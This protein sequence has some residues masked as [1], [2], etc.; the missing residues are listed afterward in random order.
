MKAV[1]FLDEDAFDD[2]YGPREK[3]EIQ[4]RLEIEE[5]LITRESYATTD[6]VWYGV[7][8][9]L[10]GWGMVAMDKVFLRRFPD[11]ELILYGAGTVQALVTPE[12]WDRNIRITSAYGANAVPVAEFTLS[13]IL[14]SLKHGWRHVRDIRLQKRLTKGHRPPGGYGSTVGLISLGMVGQLVAQKLQSFDLNVIAYDPFL[15][16]D[17]AAKWNVTLCSLEEIFARADVVSC[18]SPWTKQTE[19]M[20]RGRHFAMMKPH[21]TFINTARGAVIAENEMIEML[22]ERPDLFALLDVTHPEPPAEG[23]PLYTLE[24]VVLTPHLAGSLGREC[25]RMGSYMIEE[26]DRYLAGQPLRYGITQ[27]KSAVL[28]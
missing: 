22:H 23:S 20:I 4:A 17:D 26:L 28:A 11:L 16:P 19:R 12:F 18:H 6:R 14:F 2:I 9:I 3:K 10:S 7:E 8:T 15:N 5:P 1:Y 21:A 24:N 27:A 13:Q 25:R